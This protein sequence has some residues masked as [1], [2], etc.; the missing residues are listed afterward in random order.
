MLQKKISVIIPVHN[1]QQY[2]SR[3]LKSVS[4]QTY[5]N[6]EIIL[7]NDNSSDSS[8]DVALQWRKNDKR[9]ICLSVDNR[10]AALT[11]RDGLKASSGEY[12]CFVDS[13]DVVHESY[14]QSMYEAITTSGASI[15]TSKI[16]TFNNENEI[17]DIAVGRGGIEFAENPAQYFF[18]H[19]HWDMRGDFVAQSI[20]AK[21]FKRKTLEDIDYG[22]LKSNVLEDNFI[23][24]QILNN[25]KDEKVAMIDNV[26][27]YYRL[28]Q[29]STMRGVLNKKIPYG[30]RE[31]EYTELFEI[32]MDYIHN[33]FSWYVD[34]DKCIY[35]LKSSEYLSMAKSIVAK[36]MQIDSLESEQI[37][38]L[39]DNN[40]LRAELQSI[41]ESKTYTTS[42]KI[43]A[44]VRKLK[45]TV[46]H[47]R[48]K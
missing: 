45:D 31:M 26:M 33:V 5:R 44:P 23:L 46:R 21:L 19:Y 48:T 39:E 42:Q 40:T 29:D 36:N 4:E 2:L 3:C 37:R 35:K 7:V 28:T 43:V 16:A 34:I 12:V 8:E 25:V 6:I 1:S 11:R 10:N 18:D 32:A 47:I 22:V 38:L 30:N 41:K 20:N 24:P 15:V 9:V 13:D 17:G 27:Y 14:V